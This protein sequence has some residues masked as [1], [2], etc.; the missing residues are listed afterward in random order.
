MWRRLQLRF[1]LKNTKKERDEAADAPKKQE[2]KPITES[3][4][5]AASILGDLLGAP[6]EEAPVKETKV[7]NDTEQGSIVDMLENRQSQE[8]EEKTS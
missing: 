8:E 4:Q 2:A 1:W 3:D 7:S 5:Q 6:A